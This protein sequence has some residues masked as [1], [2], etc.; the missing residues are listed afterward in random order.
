M[1]EKADKPEKPV[2]VTSPSL[3]PLEEYMRV[4]E[5]AWESGILTHNGPLVR[6]LEQ[7]LM[8]YLGI[9]NLVIVT[10]GT[11]ALQLAIKALRLKGE[12]ITTPFTWI[13]TV[14][15]I[16][17]ENCTPVFVDID[18]GTFNIDPGKIEDAITH[19]TCA[20]MPVHVFGNPCEVEK[21]EDIARRHNLKIIYDA[22]HAMCVDYKGKSILEYGD[23][24][25]TS[26]HATKI[27]NTGEGGACITCNDE[28]FERLRRLRFFG[29]NS[30]KDIVDDGCN[31]KMTEVHAALGL[32]NLTHQ[33]EVLK[34][35]R[36]IFERY[37]ENLKDVDSIRFQKF[38]K[39]AYNY[40]YL[41][42][43]LSS[44]EK[45]LEIVSKLN[46]NNIFPRRYFYP[47]LNTVKAVAPYSP[48][49]LSEDLAQRI[50]CLP[51]HSRLEMEK[52]DLI[53][54][55]IKRSF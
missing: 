46:K 2:Y 9:K 28:L 33:D 3:A 16:Q 30:A 11:I 14:S 45:V 55:W 24:S 47:S 54:E 36:I 29:H 48:M 41:P 4:L 53:S 12:I 38:D 40:S 34:K 17:W 42:V 6:K 8:A 1:Q 50:L 32:A 13:A 52:V 43:V 19:R 23:I 15:A 18:P 39:K 37:F 31:G 27:F 20:I 51:S 25:A 5:S 26:F 35:R 7:E 49:P 22:A 44:E 10:N 21:I